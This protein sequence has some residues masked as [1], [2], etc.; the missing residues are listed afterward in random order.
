MDGAWSRR[1]FP[2]VVFGALLAT[3][4]S[5]G[6]GVAGPSG[7][8]ESVSAPAAGD[9]LSTPASS[10]PLLVGTRVQ[11]SLDGSSLSANAGCNTLGG[12]YTVEGNTLI[13][14]EVASTMMGCAE[15]L[16]NQDGRLSAFLTNRPTLTESPDG[17]TLTGEGEATL[18]M[19]N[20]TVAEPNR[21]LESTVWVLDGLVSGDVASSA[22]GFDGVTLL[23]AGGA[24]TLTS[25]CNLGAT[26]YILVAPDTL[27]SAAMTVTDIPGSSGCEFIDEGVDAV[28]ALFGGTMTATVEAG[29]LTLSRGDQGATF[30]AS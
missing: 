4:V 28:A 24:A 21:T 3:V 17:F 10:F 26:S 13:V 8:Q 25:P 30:V 18:V 20:S 15:D 2:G 5:A 29:T 14:R 16:M 7:P 11:V 1:W 9:Y 27:D 22:A 23:F 19:V 12:S 6:C